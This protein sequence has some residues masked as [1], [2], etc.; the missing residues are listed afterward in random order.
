MKC[1]R[2][3][4]PIKNFLVLSILYSG[5]SKEV[6]EIYQILLLEYEIEISLSGLYVVINKMKKD[7]LIYSR[8]ADGKKY[9]LTITQTGKEEFNETKKILEKVFS[10]IY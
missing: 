10:K 1:K 3:A 2:C 4:M 8:Y 9:V 5:Q 6:S 7:K